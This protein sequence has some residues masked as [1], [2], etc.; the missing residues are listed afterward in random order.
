MRAANW[1]PAA[2]AT[3][4][5]TLALSPARID[6][7]DGIWPGERPNSAGMAPRPGPALKA[8]SRARATESWLPPRPG[9]AVKE[10]CRLRT[11]SVG[12]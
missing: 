6:S 9:V 1:L 3:D 11:A 5:P 4:S 7:V 12:V 8:V 10:D 2:M